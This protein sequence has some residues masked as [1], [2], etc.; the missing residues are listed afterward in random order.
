MDCVVEFNDVSFA[1]EKE[2]ILRDVTFCIPQGEF[3]VV[4]GPNGGGKSTLLKVLLGLIPIKKGSV[5]MFGT[6]PLQGGS[7]VGY[8]P[9]DAN[10][11]R[12]LPVMVKEV[13]QMGQL[14]KAGKSMDEK[15]VRESLARFGLWELRNTRIGALSQGQRQRVLLARALAAKPDLLVLDEPCA[16]LD[17]EG[18]ELLSGVLS[19]LSKAITIIIVSHDLLLVSG[20]S[21]AM[22]RVNRSVTYHKD[23][24]L[25]AGMR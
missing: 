13:V 1:Y 8:V 19:E 10:L 23:A 2:Y 12:K 9:Q 7:R 5:S 4:I 18:H 11:N 16:S 3:A 17:A 6:A 25:R 14:P 22:I 15:I 24:G 20:L 21:T